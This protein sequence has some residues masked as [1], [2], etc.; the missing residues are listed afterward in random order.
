MRPLET[1]VG[2]TNVIG[3]PR[4]N[5]GG[6]EDDDDDDDE[7]DDDDDDVWVLVAKQ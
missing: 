7:D 5:D 6:D 2:N 3:C 4:S 1:W